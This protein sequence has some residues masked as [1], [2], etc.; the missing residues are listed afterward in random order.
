MASRFF[1]Q[2][3]RNELYLEVPFVNCICIIGIKLVST[4][5]VFTIF[6]N[7]QIWYQVCTEIIKTCKDV[8]HSLSGSIGSYGGP[9]FQRSRDRI[10]LTTHA[11]LICIAYFHVQVVFRSSALYRVGWN[12]Q[13][14][15]YTC[16]WRHCS[17]LAVVDYNWEF[18]IGLLHGNYGKY[19]IIDLTDSSSRFTTW[20]LQAIVNFTFKWL[21]HIKMLIVCT[22]VCYL[23]W[24]LSVML[25]CFTL[26]FS[27]VYSCSLH[28]HSN[29]QQRLSLLD[30]Y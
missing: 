12:G 16:L 17:Q 28:V 27:S 13:L 11:L 24:L 1:L 10:P 22:R 9:V 8:F 29:S 15:G 19:V 5:V 6:E 14:I 2:M 7:F 30:F 4:R 26:R 23:Y 21:F 25:L 3:I 18:L 20:R